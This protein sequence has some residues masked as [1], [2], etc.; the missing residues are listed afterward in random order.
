MPI[1]LEIVSPDRLLLSEPVDMVVIPATEGDMGILEGHTPII[2]TLRGGTVA[3]YRND[4]IADR[5]FVA[6]GFAEVTGERCTVLVNE[7][8][9]VAELRRDDADTRLRAALAAYNAMPD[10]DREAQELA[11]DEI[12]STQARVE[13]IDAAASDAHHA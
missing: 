11:Q 10:T 6:S 4:V 2:V 13:A 12:Q 1:L 7:A 8:V 5:I 3:L 9:P